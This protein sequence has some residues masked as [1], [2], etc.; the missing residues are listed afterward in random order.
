MRRENS[1]YLVNNDFVTKVPLYIALTIQGRE[2]I[3]YQVGPYIFFNKFEETADGK[4]L[5]NMLPYWFNRKP[6]V[7]RKINQIMEYATWW[8]RVNK[9]TVKLMSGWVKEN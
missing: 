9:E 7:D 4:Y 5:I 1:Y 8:C 2:A 3:T 6:I